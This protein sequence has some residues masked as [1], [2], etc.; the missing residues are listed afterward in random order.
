MVGKL[1]AQE[2]SIAL[3]QLGSDVSNDRIQQLLRDAEIDGDGRLDFKEVN[4][5]WPQLPPHHTP[6]KTLTA[7]CM[8]TFS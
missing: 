3:Q 1:D 5:V 6:S 7:T 8:H 2:L 4:P